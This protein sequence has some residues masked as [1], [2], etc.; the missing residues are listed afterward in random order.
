MHNCRIRCRALVRR[1][2]AVMALLLSSC[3]LVPSAMAHH[4]GGGSTAGMPIPSLAHGQMA[5][6]AENR[7]AI[8]DLA[9]RQPFQDEVF[10]KLRNFISVQYFSCLGGMVPGSLDD[11]TSPFN[12][13]SHAYLSA[14][15]ALLLHMRSMRGDQSRVLA[16]IDRIDLQM[17]AGGTALILCRYSDEPFNTAQVIRPRWG[18]VPGHGG[19]L[20][21][22]LGVA[23]IC[24]CGAGAGLRLMRTPRHRG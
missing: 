19:S 2:I 17:L 3:G 24:L 7:S 9:D 10:L 16:L 11:E 20:L 12:E 5:V 23:A 21:A 8:L 18:D 4:A 14:T 22:F 15:R 13:C 6:I 1:V